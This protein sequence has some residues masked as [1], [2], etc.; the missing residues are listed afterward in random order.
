LTFTDLFLTPLYLVLFYI[1][2]FSIR[3]RLTSSETRKYFIPAFS[4][5]VVGALSLGLIYQFYYG[6]GDTFF[7]YRQ[8]SYLLDVFLESPVTGIDLFF[9]ASPAEDGTI[10]KHAA[11]I[12]WYNAP[13]EYFM[14]RCIAVIGFFSFNSYPVISLFFAT[15]SFIG[16]W[17]L[18]TTFLKIYPYHKSFAW[19]LFFVPTLF[20]WGSGVL[21]DTLTLGSLGFLF[22]YFYRIFI[23]KRKI[24]KSFIYFFIF[25]YIIFA[26]KVYILLSFLPAALLWVFIEN[27]KFINNALLKFIATPFLIL[28]GIISSYYMATN[29]TKGDVKYDIDNIAERT[30]VNADYLYKISVQ[31]GGSAY[32]LGNMD[33]SY[34]SMISLAPLAINVSLFR[35]YLW[36]VRNPFM[37]LS[38]MESAILFLL[39]ITVLFRKGIFKTISMLFKQPFLGFCLLFSLVFA[40]AVGLNSYNFGTLVRY[41]IPLIPFYIAAL[42]IVNESTRKRAVRPEF[43]NS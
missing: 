38:A 29:L 17:R 28:I 30:R 16:L 7:F 8:G 35:P 31:Q 20:F 37:L 39:T 11:N 23:E 42:V 33:G 5:K 9:H 4:L 25:G 10:Y 3:N 14:I 13:S 19:A 26:V 32:Y 40:F 22:F 1:Y 21:K 18:Y 43:T 12:Y 6:G 27:R 36:E 41:K 2:I 15:F 34:A 24:V